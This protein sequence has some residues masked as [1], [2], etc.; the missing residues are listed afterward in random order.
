MSVKDLVDFIVRA[1]NGG[2]L[3]WDSV[4]GGI[5]MADRPTFPVTSM[6]VREVL[7]WQQKVRSKGYPSSAV[8]GPQF[9]YKTLVSLIPRYA[10]M[11]DLFDETTQRNL[12][13]A[14]L[15]GRGLDTYLAGK[16]SAEAFADALAREWA[17]LPVII[18][19]KA[20][21]SY[22]AGDGLNKALVTIEATLA[23]V[24]SALPGP[25]PTPVPEPALPW[26][27]RLVRAIAALFRRG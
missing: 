14:L 6:K 11:D 13:L 24:R 3:N 16:V 1:E 23:A 27:T 18:G 26:Y 19:P 22:Y 10:G 17:S 21:R 20:G 8:G 25:E 4:Y 5:R 9:I 12:A 7:A 2:R 15:R